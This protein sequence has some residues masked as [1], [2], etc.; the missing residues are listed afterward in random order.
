[1]ST[2]LLHLTNFSPVS[3]HGTVLSANN[4]G[5]S[6]DINMVFENNIISIENFSAN[7]TCQDKYENIKKN[8]KT[9]CW[10]TVICLMNCV[11]EGNLEDC[12]MQELNESEN[13]NHNEYGVERILTTRT[14][15]DT[16]EKEYLV[17][18]TG[19]KF[20]QSTWEPVNNLENAQKC[21]EYHNNMLHNSRVAYLSRKE[22]N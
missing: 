9:I 1:M 3:V 21:I 22:A 20:Q 8:K 7:C 17:K 11:D 6:Y 12:A 16:Q 14:N 5:W 15:K 19:Y 2:H 4:K 13:I 10:H 18:W